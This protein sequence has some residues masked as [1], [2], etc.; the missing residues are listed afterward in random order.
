MQTKEE[1]AK[2][3]IVEDE[4]IN[5]DVL[6]GLL[7][8]FCRTVVAKDGEQAFKRMKN[9]P[10]PDLILL[11]IIMPEMDGYEVCRRLK[12]DENTC[13]IPVIFLTAKSATEDIIAGFKLGAVD[14]VTKPFNPAELIA[15][16]NTHIQLKKTISALE[17]ALKE[18][19]TLKGLLPICCSCK[20]I[21]DDKGYWNQIE[22][23]IMARSEVEFT[24]G[25]CQECA[26][27][28]YPDLDIFHK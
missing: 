4:K 27:K 3:L 6:V 5:V 12:S 2:V 9:P 28:L 23:Y 1:H 14:Y 19:K 22:S 20:K 13:D 17:N 7:K 16:V 10:L 26:K 24:H 8:P 11:D 15:R 25:I 18:I 21:R